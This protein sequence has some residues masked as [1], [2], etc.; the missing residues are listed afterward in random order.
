MSLN[1]KYILVAGGLGYIGSHVTVKLLQSGY[2]VLI[3]DNLSN[4]TIEVIDQIK[5][6][7]NK[8]NITIRSEQ[9]IFKLTD[10]T[11]KSEVLDLFEQYHIEGVI[12]MAGLKAVGESVKF[13]TRY[14]QTNLNII[15]NLLEVMNTH[16]CFKLIFSSSS[17]VY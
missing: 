7:L 9:L 10:L 2:H 11:V 12:A 3:A 4:S 1:P 14:Y 13:P 5:Q 16:N 15:T 8:E 6:V 17:T